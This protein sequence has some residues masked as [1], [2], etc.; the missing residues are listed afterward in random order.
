MN[1]YDRHWHNAIN[2]KL[3]QAAAA[4]GG[5]PPWYDMWTRLG[6]EASERD[7]L[8]F[9]QAVRNARSL[10]DEAAFYLLSWQI[11][12]VRDGVTEKYLHELEERL[13]TIQSEHGIID[14]ESAARGEG[15]AAYV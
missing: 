6:P 3:A 14:V 9:Y 15:P 10:P 12:A 8:A 13:L 5:P 1:R 4:A 2:T 7:R 11:D